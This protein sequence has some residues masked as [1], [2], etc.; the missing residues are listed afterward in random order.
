MVTPSGA[1]AGRPPG[2][3]ARRAPATPAC[4][5][6]GHAVKQ[7]VDGEADQADVPA[8]ARRGGRHAVIEVLRDTCCERWT[9]KYPTKTKT[10]ESSAPPSKH[11]GQHADQDHR[12]HEPGPEGDQPLDEPELP[13]E[14]ADHDEGAEDVRAGGERAS[15][16]A[17]TQSPWRAQQP[18]GHVERGIVHHQRQ[19]TLEHLPDSRPGRNADRHQ[20]LAGDRQVRARTAAPAARTSST[21]D[22]TGAAGR[23]AAARAPIRSSAAPSTAGAS[24]GR[25]GPPAPP[26]PP[27]PAMAAAAPPRRST[28]EPRHESRPHPC[29]TAPSGPQGPSTP[30]RRHPATPQHPPRTAAAE[31]LCGRPRFPPR[32]NSRRASA[33]WPTL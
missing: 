1:C 28:S 32:K 22:A 13:V 6:D 16:R 19:E 15:V 17:C 3:A 8:R 29:S 14:V 21:A 23:A 9:P 11:L 10:P 2:R 7:T 33:S 5:G 26:G 27:A 18:I 25:R 12:E 20:V 31:P 24:A 4:R 30:A